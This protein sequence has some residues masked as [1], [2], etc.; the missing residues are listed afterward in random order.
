MTAAGFRS[1]GA[2]DPLKHLVYGGDGVGVLLTVGYQGL[3][4]V[5]NRLNPVLPHIR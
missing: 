5:S 4:T 1:Q 3:N 2:T